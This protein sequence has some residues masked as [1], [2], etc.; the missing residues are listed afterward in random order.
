MISSEKR[1]KDNKKSPMVNQEPADFSSVSLL[2]IG[3]QYTVI[4]APAHREQT[5]LNKD[6]RASYQ[7]QTTMQPMD[8]DLDDDGSVYV[9][10]NRS[11]TNVVTP[12]CERA[13]DQEIARI[14]DP[15]NPFFKN[16]AKE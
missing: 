15:H 7:R 8:Q 10:S 1:R 14:E 3:G 9:K 2:N 5:S 6:V 11:S 4:E 16:L 12:E 13:C